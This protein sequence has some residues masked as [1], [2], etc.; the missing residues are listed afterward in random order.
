VR[1]ATT[2]KPN[3]RDCQWLKIIAN[4]GGMRCTFVNGK[5]HFTVGELE[6]PDKTARRLISHQWLIGDD[7]SAWSYGSFAQSYGVLK[8][9]GGAS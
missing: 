3:G 5:P 1:R 6:V 7:A 9:A 4:H 2:A 8:P